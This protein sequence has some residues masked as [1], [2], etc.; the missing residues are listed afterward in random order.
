MTDTPSPAK[1]DIRGPKDGKRRSF[2]L[3]WLV[4]FFALAVILSV[5]YQTYQDR[6][7]LVEIT[8]INGSG[9]SKETVIKYR[10]I[11]I[12]IVEKV[13]FSDGLDVVVVEARVDQKIAPYLDDDAEFWVV[14]PDVTLRG[15]SG[16]DTV[17]SGA[18]I[19]GKWDTEAD[20][21]Q[22]TFTGL[23]DAP[24]LAFSEEGVEI[25]LRAPSGASLAQ[26]APILHKGLRVGFI[27]EP[28]LDPDGVGVTAAAFIEEEYVDYVT[29]NTRF[30]DTSGFSISVG[31]N[32]LALDVDSIASLIEGGIAFDTVV[33]GGT[34][35]GQ[36]RSPDVFDIFDNESAARESLFERPDQNLM[37]IGI[38][39]DETVNGLTV[40]SAVKFQ[41]V[42]VGEVTAINAIVVEEDG[43]RRVRLRTTLELSP[44]RIGISDD[45]SAEDAMVILA[46]FVA[47]GLRARLVTGNLLTGSL[48]VE[49]IDVPDADIA[50]LDTSRDPF[51]IIPTTTSEVS[52]VAAT[53]EGVLSRINDLPIEELLQGA[54]DLMA[55]FESL[56]TD[57]DLRAAPEELLA[58]LGDVRSIIGSE[59]VQS[60]PQSLQSALA[61]IEQIVADI[62]VIVQD[63][64]QADLIGSITTTLDTT[65]TTIA[66]IGDASSA[67][68]QV[69]AEIEALTAKANALDLDALLTQ[70][71]QTLASIDTLVASEDVAALPGSVTQALDE[72]RTLVSDVRD[73]GA[74]EN[75]NAALAAT[76]NAARSVATSVQD[77]PDLTQR[78]MDLVTQLQVATENLPQI[79]AE[80]EALAVKANSVEIDALV[81][82]AT[83]TL[84][85]ISGI[86]DTQ[87][88][89]DL[90]AALTSSLAEVDG[91]LAEI[92]E[93]G[94]VENVNAALASA[95]EAAR[96]IETAAEG[97]PALSRQTTQLVN[98]L[99]AVAAVY[100]ERGRFTADT[101]ATLRDIQDAADAVSS[102]ARAIQRNPNSLLTGR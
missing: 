70:T 99:N 75:L 39:F 61:G 41:G 88:A 38:L 25:V 62:S 73:G 82:Q 44:T 2:A 36:S 22:T 37:T 5:A 83:T 85:S 76:S 31:A 58:I 49:L 9:I 13:G 94:A 98:T 77:L 86:L 64:T 12:G 18:Y 79:T 7:I 56:A 3:I 93:G 34:P 46:G 28:I 67:L 59:G 71:T 29:T 102:L 33:S 50:F 52:D 92:R 60:T 47:Q 11:D 23:E 15:V 72:V 100:G 8:F 81:E 84:A 19:A 66:S 26:G 63:A 10:D 97:L 95:S 48:D 89:R 17:L 27:D 101:A 16:L 42:R 24:L 45:T 65:N 40:G 80:I 90:P 4:P 74:V 53:A 69:I 55:S 96:A 32:G 1:L 6:G 54:I 68:P 20:V 30:W 14:R 78:A 35:I 43:L 51:P 91:L 57:G 87:G 21:A